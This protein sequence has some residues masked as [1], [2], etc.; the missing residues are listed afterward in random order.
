MKYKKVESTAK[1]LSVLTAY[2]KI[3]RKKR[4]NCDIIT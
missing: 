3:K 4:K 1:K 2:K